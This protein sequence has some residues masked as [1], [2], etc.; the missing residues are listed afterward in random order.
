MGHWQHKTHSAEAW[1]YLDDHLGAQIAMLQECVPPIGQPLFL[2]RAVNDDTGLR[3]SGTYAWDEIGGKRDWGT[4]VFTAGF[5]LRKLDLTLSHPGTSV[6]VEVVLPNQELVTA[7]SIYGLMIKTHSITTLHRVFSDLTLV[8]EDR[9]RKIILGGDL[10]ASLQWD[11]QQ[12]GR[13]HEI[14]FDRIKNFGL[15]DCLSKFQPYPQQTWR[16]NGV[17]TPWQ[18]DYLFMSES[19]VERVKQCDVRREPALKELS[20]HNP[21]LATLDL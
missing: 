11:E 9:K 1:A 15:H 3:N 20:D 18:L 10:N 12:R 6:G 16:K 2:G 8:L 4:G 17:M 14:L 13:S 7:I 21:I 5:P 19:L